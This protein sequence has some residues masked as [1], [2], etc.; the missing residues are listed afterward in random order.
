MTLIKRT[1][2]LQNNLIDVWVLGI[3]VYTGLFKVKINY[4]IS[5][6]MVELCE[7]IHETILKMNLNR[8]FFC[9]RNFRWA[10]IHD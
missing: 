2:K 6:K 7:K 4:I 3:L 9:P 10:C 8:V 5:Y 1:S